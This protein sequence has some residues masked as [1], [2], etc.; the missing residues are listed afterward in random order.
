MISQCEKNC[1]QGDDGVWGRPRFLV[2]RDPGKKKLLIMV[3]SVVHCLICG[4][5]GE[6][7]TLAVVVLVVQQR[8][9]ESPNLYSISN[10]N[11]FLLS[12]SAFHYY[13]IGA[14]GEGPGTRGLPGESEMESGKGIYIDITSLGCCGFFGML[15]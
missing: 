8:Q 14:G 3:P 13:N 10:L 1:E 7:D 4:N 9:I 12:K 6:R 5:K 15:N 11:V 2:P